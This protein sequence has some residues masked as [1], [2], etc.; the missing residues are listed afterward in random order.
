MTYKNMR[1][2][3][4]IKNTPKSYHRNPT[5]SSANFR[6]FKIF[7]KNNSI[8]QNTKTTSII[9]PPPSKATAQQIHHPAK[10]VHS[11]RSTTWLREES[12]GGAWGGG[13]SAAYCGGLEALRTWRQRRRGL[14]L[15]HHVRRRGD[16]ILCRQV[17]ST[18]CRRQTAA[19]PAAPCAPARFLSQRTYHRL[20]TLPPQSIYCSNLSRSSLPHPC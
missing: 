4:L 18:S 6:K 2:Q 5:L 16:R 19:L 14:R 13:S 7:L 9:P 20:R 8:T 1:N 15:T 12:G 3:N 17:L 11:N 10:P